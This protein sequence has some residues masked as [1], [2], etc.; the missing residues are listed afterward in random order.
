MSNMHM[1]VAPAYFACVRIRISFNIMYMTSTY[2][3][4]CTQCYFVLGIVVN[5]FVAF[6]L[7]SVFCGVHLKDGCIELHFKGHLVALL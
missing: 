5:A 6:T 1:K 2:V 4:T 3:C 7:F